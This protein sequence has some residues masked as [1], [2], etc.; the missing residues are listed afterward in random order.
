M[1]SASRAAL[2]FLLRKSILQGRPLRRDFGAP[3]AR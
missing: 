1:G 3:S 2:R